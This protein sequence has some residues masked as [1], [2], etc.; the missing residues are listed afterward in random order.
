MALPGLPAELAPMRCLLSIVEPVLAADDTV[1]INAP[2][3]V[4]GRAAVVPLR[5]GRT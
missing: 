5:P 1:R 3:V 4:P 2:P